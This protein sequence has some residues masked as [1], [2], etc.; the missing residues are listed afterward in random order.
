MSYLDAKLSIIETLKLVC[1]LAEIEA[2]NGNGPWAYA[3]ARIDIAID[4]M[5]QL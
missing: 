2:A 1:A 3:I 5:G 4:D